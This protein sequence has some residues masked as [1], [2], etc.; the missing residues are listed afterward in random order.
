MYVGLVTHDLSATARRSTAPAL[1]AMLMMCFVAGTWLRTINCPVH[2]AVRP[3]LAGRGKQEPLDAGSVCSAS[4]QLSAAGR[5]AAA[6]PWLPEELRGDSA[7]CPG[8]SSAAL[9]PPAPMP[10]HSPG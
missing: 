6:L 5:A 4:H 1:D 7:A 10:A 3:M 2:L 8:Q 9:L